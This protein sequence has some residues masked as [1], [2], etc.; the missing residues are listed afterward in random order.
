MARIYGGVV[1]Q[2]HQFL[3]DRF[4]KEV[5]VARRQVG[6]ANAALKQNIPYDNEV[7]RLMVIA[8]A[9]GGVARG[10]QHF[11][12][13]LSK[14]QDVAVVNENF[15]QYRFFHI[16]S[17][18]FAVFFAVFQKRQAVFMGER[19]QFIGFRNKTAAQHV[20]DVTMGEQLEYWLE[21]FF[22]NEIGELFFFVLLVA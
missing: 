4:D 3:Q 12:F 15:R 7:A 11:Q 8:E 1:G 17:E 18:G 16:K 13:L 9:A 6:P 10:V 5:M 22:F 14:H 19:L 20:V 21:L 2:D